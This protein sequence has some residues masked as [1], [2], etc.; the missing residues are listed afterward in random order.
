MAPADARPAV[1]GAAAFMTLS[2]TPTRDALR[3]VALPLA[4]MA[5]TA[6]RPTAGVESTGV[7]VRV[8]GG[9]AV[10]ELVAG[11]RDTD[12]S[13]DGATGL[14]V[15][16]CESGATA[17]TAEADGVKVG[18]GSRMG[19]ADD[20]V[21]DGV[22]G[23]T[24]GSDD[25]VAASEVDGVAALLACGC[26][27]VEAESAADEVAVADAAGDNCGEDDA[28]NCEGDDDA[29]VV[30]VLVGGSTAGTAES[31]PDAL[32]VA[33]GT[34]VIDA[35]VVWMAVVEAHVVTV[36]VSVTIAV[37]VPE[38]VGVRVGAAVH[39]AVGT[40][41]RDAVA[42]AVGDVDLVVVAVALAVALR[43]AL[44]LRV[45][46]TVALAVADNVDVDVAIGVPQA[47]EVGDGV[48]VAAAEGLV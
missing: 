7:G 2:D 24:D 9:D 8:T 3:I 13:P 42:V 30:M 17:A 36:A 22:A 14:D 1:H 18:G 26:D 19:N 27:F 32:D 11:T 38:V 21:S 29:V 33:E 4:V 41:V 45:A 35:D 28:G 39:V 31:D 46:K 23:G 15:D 37:T 34:A 47:V 43:V 48:D 6:E 16:V 25:A 10:G 44:A 40:G 12:A 20:T 5:A